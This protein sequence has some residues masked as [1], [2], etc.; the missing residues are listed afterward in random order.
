VGLPFAGIWKDHPD[1]DA[2]QEHIAEARRHLDAAESDV[3]HNA[4][5]ETVPRP[6]TAEQAE[7][8]RLGHLSTRFGTTLQVEGDEVVV[9][10]KL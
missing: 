5:N 8:D 6:I 10:R 2:V 4:R 1:L 9:W 7:V 3:R